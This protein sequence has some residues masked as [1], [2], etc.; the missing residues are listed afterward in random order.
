[1]SSAQHM[2]MKVKHG[3]ATMG[4]GIDDYAIAGIGNPLL[5][6]DRI[7]GQHQASEQLDIRILKFGN[8]THMSS[9]DDERMR[10]RLGIDIVKRRPGGPGPDRR[11][12]RLRSPAAHREVRLLGSRLRGPGHGR[13]Q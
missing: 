8:R 11:R 3:L 6:C 9:G 7:A 5:S 12:F 1:M 2:E 4:A 10:R 13:S